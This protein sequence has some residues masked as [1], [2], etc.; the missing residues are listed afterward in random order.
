M[1][2][3][4]EIFKPNKI[5]IKG[6][7]KILDVDSGK[8]VV[9]EKNKDVKSLYQYLN[10]RQFNNYPEII[11]E[12]D[13]LYVYD[14]LENINIPIN[15]KSADMANLLSLLHNKTA[16]FKPVTAD[17]M[18]S[19]HEEI[20]NHILYIE[21]Y[22]NKLF[23]TIASEVVMSPSNYLLIRNS[24]KLQANFNFIKSELDKWF[25]MMS[26]KTKERVVYCHNNLSI[27]HYVVNNN[28]Y[29]ISWDNYVID[30]PVL[31]LINLYQNDYNKY[32]FSNF[33]DNYN[34]KFPLNKEELKLFFLMI[35]LPREIVLKDNEYD[36]TKEVNKLLTYIYKTEKLIRPYYTP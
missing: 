1:K 36:N 17:Y 18:K 12:V 25:K 5:T 35:S 22:Y 30:T 32:E 19:I 24:S 34:K 29:F 33:F 23:E 11:D 9:K 2:K 26:E 7:S 21:N 3:I 31:D 14:Y 15:Q 6:K 4:N 13:N 16:Y 8:C 10:T 28:E 20:E 27:D